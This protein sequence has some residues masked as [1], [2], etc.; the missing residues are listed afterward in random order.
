MRYEKIKS[1]GC[2]RYLKCV[3]IF[4]KINCNHFLN[5]LNAQIIS[6]WLDALYVVI[7]KSKSNSIVSSMHLNLY[8][9]S[10][11]LMGIMISE[12]ADCGPQLMSRYLHRNAIVQG[13]SQQS[14][15]YLAVAE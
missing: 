13:T 14:N 3:K 6:S 4:G 9:L 1:S 2:F 12:T 15:I 10:Q 7:A 8:D 5:R 11:S